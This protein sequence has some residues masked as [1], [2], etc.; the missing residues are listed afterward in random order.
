VPLERGQHPSAASFHAAWTAFQRF[1]RLPAERRGG[2]L[3]FEFGVFESRD[4]GTSFEV[5][6]TRRYADVRQVHL[7]VH[8]PVAAFI[9]ITRDLRAT[10]C[11]PG[12]G[13]TFRCF[14]AGDDG[15]VPHPCR[16][17]PGGASGYRIGDMT[18]RASQAGGRARWLRGVASS[19][20][21]AA[22]FARH[23]R[24]DGYEVWQ[25]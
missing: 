3:L 25:E 16:I 2:D 22:L 15:L 14:F 20:V 7:M 23:V 9:A 19:P 11:L 5:E 10:P 12:G 18:L 13:C 6:L 17:V 24:P 4:Y 1:A 21:F 8:F